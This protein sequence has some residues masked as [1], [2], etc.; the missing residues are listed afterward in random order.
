MKKTMK[1]LIGLFLAMTLFYAC[2]DDD[3]IVD[4]VFLSKLEVTEFTSTAMMNNP[5]GNSELRKVQVYT[6]KDYDP[7]GSTAYPVVYLLHGLPFSENAF[8]SKSA[9]DPWIGGTSPFQSYPDFPEEGF[10]SWIDGLIESGKI[11]PMIIVMPNAMNENFGFSFY[12]NSN[13]NGRFEDYIVNDLV[14]FVDSNYKTL[15]NK[16]GRALIGFSQGAYAAVKFGMLYPQKFGVVAG[17]SGL[18]YLDGI[19]MNGE[20]FVAE[21]PDGFNGPDPDKFITSAVYA[22]SSAWSPNL[23]NPPFMVDLPFEFPSGDVIAEVRN[24]WLKQCAF[25]LME[26]HQAQIRTLNGLYI[27]CG[28]QDELGMMAMVQ[29]FEAKMTALGIE[30]T[31]ETFEGGH[32]NRLYSRLELSLAFCSQRMGP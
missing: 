18:L 10:K 17:H 13:L 25:N 14:K 2:D 6:P 5:M 23:N 29:A 1:L 20:A 11:D 8:V 4:P 26:Q 9:W 15:S 28:N 19:L 3:D 16:D 24:R 31:F 22:M 12:S 7:N 21:N 32:F 27:D 30:H